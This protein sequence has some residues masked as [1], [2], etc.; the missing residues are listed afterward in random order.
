LLA[1]EVAIETDAKKTCPVFRLIGQKPPRDLS[2]LVKER[3]Q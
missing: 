1:I 3:V 2:R